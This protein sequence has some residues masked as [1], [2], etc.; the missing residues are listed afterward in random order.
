MI[1]KKVE[2]FIKYFREGIDINELFFENDE[3]YKRAFSYL[4]S[5]K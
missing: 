3:Q 1:C 5:S 4:M 2:E